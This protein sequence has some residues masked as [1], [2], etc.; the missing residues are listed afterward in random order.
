[1]DSCSA[2]GT[3][4]SDHTERVDTLTLPP[5]CTAQSQRMDRGV[6]AVLK[7]RYRRL[8][9]AGITESVGDKDELPAAAKHLKAG[10][11]GLDEVYDPNMLDVR[12]PV[13]QVWGKCRRI[14]LRGIF[15]KLK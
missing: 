8:L 1:M 12:D 3:D 10:M 9:R 15:L 5:N 13:N 4:V 11:R 2:Y 14:R 7:L 6:V